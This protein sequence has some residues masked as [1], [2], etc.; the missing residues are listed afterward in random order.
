MNSVRP[1]LPSDVPAIVTLVSE[2]ARRGDLLPRTAASVEQTVADWYVAAVAGQII[3]CGSL[4]IYGSHLAELRSLAVH[5]HVKGQ[6]W[7][8]ILV[9]ALVTEAKRRQI[10]TLFALTR[11]VSF[12]ERCGFTTT[13][14]VFFPEKVWRDCEQCPLK[15]RC[16][17]TA[18]V[19]ELVP[20]HASRSK[21]LP[22]AGYQWAD[23]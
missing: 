16:D 11:A 15:H 21:R 1:A 6:G 20:G 14:R 8:A 18:V 2:H 7:G 4:F 19:L 23:R 5:D 9:Q 17:E 22:V 10:P 13:D 12:F 3:A